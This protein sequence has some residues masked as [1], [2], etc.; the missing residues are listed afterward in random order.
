M[1]DINLKKNRKFRSKT[2]L[3]NQF[4]FL[5]LKLYTHKRYPLQSSKLSLLSRFLRFV[6]FKLRSSRLQT[7]REALSDE[8]RTKRRKITGHDLYKDILGSPKFIVAPMVEQSE[9]VR[10]S[11]RTVILLMLTL[12]LRIALEDTFA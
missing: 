2:L 12:L 3:Y 8:H 4:I 10:S 6:D 9:L 5:F 7:M 11:T 1:I